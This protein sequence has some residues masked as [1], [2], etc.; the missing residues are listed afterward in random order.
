VT[1]AAQFYFIASVSNSTACV[2]V[3]HSLCQKL[4]SDYPDIC[5]KECIAKHICPNTCSKCGK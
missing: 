2:D 3:D 4:K 1:I 5:L